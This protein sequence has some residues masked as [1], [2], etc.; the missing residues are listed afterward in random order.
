VFDP[1]SFSASMGYYKGKLDIVIC[2]GRWEKTRLNISEDGDLAAS[3]DQVYISFF[4]TTG[5]LPRTEVA[6][7]RLT[8]QT[9]YPKLYVVSKGNDM[10]ER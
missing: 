2:R 7:L 6:G 8:C 5:D 10:V 4:P 9:M 3:R 1:T